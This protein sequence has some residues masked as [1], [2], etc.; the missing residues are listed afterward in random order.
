[1]QFEMIYNSLLRACNKLYQEKKYLIDEK[2]NELTIASHLATYLR[3]YIKMWDVDT[4]YRREGPY[5]TSKRDLEDNIII[6]D[7]IVHKNGPDGPNIAAIEI[8]GYWNYEDRTTD[9]AKLKAIQLKHHYS[10]LFR[11]E[12]L[13]DRADIIRVEAD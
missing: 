9:I 6:P 12:I 5:R 2:S 3:D 11:I 8:K 7:I 1:M 4:D 10:Y 13:P